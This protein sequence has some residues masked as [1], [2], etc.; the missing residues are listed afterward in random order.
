MP[1]KQ[2]KY[3]DNL[4]NLGMS[5]ITP[6][7][8]VPARVAREILNVPDETLRR[9]AT[10]GKIQYK[11]TPGN[12]RLYNINSLTCSSTTTTNDEQQPEEDMKQDNNQDDC[13]EESSFDLY[14]PE[15]AVLQSN[16]LRPVM[17]DNTWTPWK[18][19]NLHSVAIRRL[20]PFL[21]QTCDLDTTSVFII[22]GLLDGINNLSFVGPLDKVEKIEL[23]LV[24]FQPPPKK[25][26]FD[27]M[28]VKPTYEEPFVVKSIRV[29][30]EL[31]R[32]ILHIH[33]QLF[34]FDGNED[35]CV[36]PFFF[37]RRSTPMPYLKSNVRFAVRVKL[38]DDSVKD[39]ISV[40]CQGTMVPNDVRVRL[41]APCTYRYTME[42]FHSW[43][44]GTL[45]TTECH[46]ITLPLSFLRDTVTAVFVSIFNKTKQCYELSALSHIVLA[47]QDYTLASLDQAGVQHNALLFGHNKSNKSDH[48]ILPFSRNILKK[49]DDTGRF[50]E[51]VNL[52]GFRDVCLL[53]ECVSGLTD[54]YEIQI[55]CT[56]LSQIDAS[57][58]PW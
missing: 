28:G 15:F 2:N 44:C 41:Y 12:H 40:V 6:P 18:G 50:S 35:S 9:W 49:D 42:T 19:V 24:T 8:Y 21:I 53:V 20:E 14:W 55:A 31:D 13:R 57:G 36:L 48:V 22:S 3:P 37:S 27:V 39:E 58:T 10:S 25:Y 33:K 17:V 1:S 52:Y 45:D 29:F 34:T 46:K 32:H 54:E 11:R 16:R 23:L 5:N 30:D 4:V 26:P 43:F 38:L 47:S 56:R 51:Y 7:N